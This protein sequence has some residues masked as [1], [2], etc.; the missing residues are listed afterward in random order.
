MLKNYITIALRN[1][2][3]QKVY[4]FI[5]VSGLAIGIAACILILL[6]VKDEL[7]FDQYHEKSERIYRVS[8]EWMN[9]DGETSLHLG[10]VAPPFG[11]LLEN[12][13]SGMI[14]YAVRFQ[15]GYS[16]LVKANGKDIQEERF[17]F[18]DQNIFK[19]FSW[20]VLDGD[21]ETAL[22]EPNAVVLTKTTAEKYFGSENVV[23]KQITYNN[24]G[25]SI[26]MK[27][28]GVMEDVPLNSHFKFDFLGSFKTIENVFGADNLARSWGSNNYA[29]YLLLGEGTAPE[30]LTAEFPGFLNN[31][32]G[33]LDDGRNRSD[34]NRLHLWPLASIHLYSHLDSEVEP[35]GDIAYVYIYS[36]VALFILVIACINFM[37]LSTARS[38]KRA[39]EVGLRK[40]L[41]AVKGLLMRQFI[42]ESVIF[43]IISLLFAVLFVLMI[44]PFF[45]DF[46]QKDLSLNVME[47]PFVALLLVGITLLVGLVA[48]SYPAFYLASFQPATILKGSHKASGK[49]I[50]LRS[51]LVIFQFWISIVLIIGV[52]IVQDQLEYMRKKDLGFNSD[53]MLVLPPS[54][55]IY[56]NFESVKQRLENNPAIEQV[57]ISSRVPSGRLLDS[58]GGEAEINGEMVDI[59]VRVADVHVDHEYLEQLEIPLAAGRYFDRSRASDSSLAFIINEATVRA[60]GWDSSEEAIGKKFNYGSRQGGEII[61]VVRD[62]HFES[63]HQPIVPIVFLV[64]QGRFSNVI[65]KVKKGMEQEALAFLQDQ[66]QFLRPGFPFTSFYIEEQFSNQYGN[67]DRLHKIVKYFSGLAVLI[68][69]LGL[70]GLASYTA[71]QRI[72]EIGIRKVMGASVPQILIL[73]TSSFTRLVLIAFILAI[74]LAWFGMDAWLSNFAFRG[75]L[76]VMSFAIGGVLALLIAWITVISQTLKAAMTNP[77]DSIRYE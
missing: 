53:N 43:S 28:T 33:P 77:V 76:Q 72:K 54:N 73:L 60:L 25:L 35:N 39:Q 67:E 56:N 75:Q 66:W 30:Q 45:N 57:T 16:P 23:G 46:V 5:N 1:I 50:S 42:L 61:G 8:R 63:L 74:P 36:I 10:H 70:F 29:T 14:E 68:A 59:N 22:L 19:V 34:V 49:K 44:L 65:V 9:K 21:P 11:P 69:A 52:G 58:Q 2:T 26:E 47:N 3:R 31:H 41:G 17:F 51:V 6:F 4:S 24:F 55:E 62:F 18:G 13:F 20:K 40:V 15:S 48:G 27:V 32:M 38:A 71:E 64:T 12:D 37:N 7:S